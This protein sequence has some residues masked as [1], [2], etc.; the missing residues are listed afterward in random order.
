MR[1]PSWQKGCF[2]IIAI[3]LAEILIRGG[4]WFVYLRHAADDELSLLYRNLIYY[5]TF[6]RLDG[7]VMGVLIALLKNWQPMGWKKLIEYGNRYL[8]IGMIGYTLV[9]F[10]FLTGTPKSF[11]ST[12]LNY[13]FLAISS[14]FFTLSALCHNS[15]LN[16]IRIPFITRLVILSYAIYLTHKIIIN[17]VQITLAN[18]HLNQRSLLPL[19]ITVIMCLLAGWVLYNLVELPFLKLREKIG[20]WEDVTS[21][22]TEMTSH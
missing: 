7:L 8:I 9:T 22:K 2:Y 3:M 15:T 5:P 20:P 12:V 18:W 17:L 21:V 1:K 13:S 6:S 4:I 14:A 11:C 16:K 10:I 19:P